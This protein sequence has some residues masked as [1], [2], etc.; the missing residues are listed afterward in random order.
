MEGRRRLTS[1]SSKR[2]IKNMKYI[3]CIDL[4]TNL[5]KIKKIIETGVDIQQ[6]ISFSTAVDDNLL[7]VLRDR[8]EGRCYMACYITSVDRI[9]RRSELMMDSGAIKGGGTI[10]V[11]FEVSA[12]IYNVGEIILAKIIKRTSDTIENIVASTET[13]DIIVQ[14]QKTLNSVTVGQHIPLVV[15]QM[16][17]NVGAPK[18]AIAA[19]PLTFSHEIT[20]YYPK[21]NQ[22]VDQDKISDILELIKQ[23]EAVYAALDAKAK[24]F[25]VG[26]MHAYNVPPKVITSDLSKVI[27]ELS[28]YQTVSRPPS[29]NL[30]DKVVVCDIQ[31]NKSDPTIEIRELTNTQIACCLLEDYY[32]GIRLIREMVELYSTPAILQAHTNLWLI[33]KQSK[34]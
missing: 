25:F 31:L 32:N 16:R 22:A 34:L 24:S 19:V 8:Y 1:I 7:M 18:I 9:V 12:I 20:L 13:C 17:Y 26:I 11:I 23:E 5:M 15:S 30:S 2:S 4:I 28:S 14:N 21:A 29:I 10:N 6:P 3:D 33:L 27:N